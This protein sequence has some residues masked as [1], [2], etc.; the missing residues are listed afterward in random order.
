MEIDNL[1]STLEKTLSFLRESE[2]SF[3]SSLS[4]EELI[5]KLEDE[6]HKSENSQQIDLGQLK[7][8]FAPIG[9]IQDT[10]IDNGWGDQYLEISEV[11]DRYTNSK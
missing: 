2:S 10:S 3:W 5:S 9:P 8:L 6:L 7:F 11:I 4:V 1:V